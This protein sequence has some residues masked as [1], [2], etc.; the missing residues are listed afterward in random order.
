MPFPRRRK[1]I[2]YRKGSGK[3]RGTMNQH[4]KTSQNSSNPSQESIIPTPPTTLCK[5]CSF[6]QW[7]ESIFE[8]NEIYFQSPDCFNDPF[9]SKFST[10]YEGT[11][12]QRV[13]SLISR[14]R[15]GPLRGE[16]K[17]DLQSRAVEVVKAGQDIPLALNSLRRSVESIR[18]RMGIFCMTHPNQK[19]NILMWSHYA[20]KHTGFCLE[21]ERANDFFG[22]ALQ[23]KEKHYSMQQL[24]CHTIA[25]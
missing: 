4:H 22:R 12:K 20:D 6:N 14:W 9:D 10:T 8:R 19:N 13:S 11:E 17:E 5:F 7:T 23:I 25:K 3:E 18:K 24:T 16:T 2:Y 1:P 21:F 15:K